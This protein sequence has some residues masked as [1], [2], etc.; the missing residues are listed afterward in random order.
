MSLRD[1]LI[2][3]AAITGMVPMKA[4]NAHLPV[5]PREIA[6][7]ARRCRDAGASIV[8][9]HA[10]D[11][12]GRPT[13]RKDVYR[14]I[15]ARVRELSPDLILCV[16]T[17]GRTFKSFEQRSEVLELNDPTPEMASLTLGSM[18]FAREESINSPQMIASLAKKMNE[19][20]IVPELECFEL[21]M[22][23]YTQYLIEHDVLK[24][25]YYCNI[26]LGSLGT[27]RAT[28]FNLTAMV[29]ALPAGATWAAAGIGKFQFETNALAIAMGG[30]V[31]VGLED[32]LWLDCARRTPAT[33]A[34]LIERIVTL[35]RATGR[36]P[37]T[38][39]DARSII[40]LGLRRDQG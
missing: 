26:L 33:N 6:Q 31:R 9:L 28:P 23:E 7:D 18:N 2:I 3:N 13:Y 10:R 25:P 12:Q 17:S 27:L 40:G 37:A 22:V 32:N 15:I 20:G 39:A 16:S 34:T 21:R 36:E 14:E 19:C 11:E 1:K 8:H 5:T 29:R 38:P 30:H 4:D 24:P 35:A